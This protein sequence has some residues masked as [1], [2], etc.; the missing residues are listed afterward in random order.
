MPEAA[1]R[2]YGVAEGLPDGFGLAVFDAFRPPALQAEL[3][4]VYYGPGA[5]TPP[6]YISTPSAD[7]SLPAPHTTGGTVDLTLTYRGHPLALGTAFDA[8]VPDAHPLAFEDRPGPVRDLRRLLHHRMVE[9]GFVG[10][11]LE[12]WH[13]EYGTCRWGRVLDEEPRFGPAAYP[14]GLPHSDGTMA[15]HSPRR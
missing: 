8:M 3:F 12:W 4:D 6:G 1:A 5:T 15:K 9:A 10:D 13:Y 14:S 2:L 11:S 7:A